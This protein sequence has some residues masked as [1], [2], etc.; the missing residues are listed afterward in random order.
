MPRHR[1]SEKLPN[2]LI[3]TIRSALG[4]E[5]PAH[6]RVHTVFGG[7]L[8]GKRLGISRPAM[9]GGKTAPAGAPLD[10][11][12]TLKDGIITRAEFVRGEPSIPVHIAHFDAG[13]GMRFSTVLDCF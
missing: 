2:R 11:Y 3:D 1:S 4:E 5:S 13:T 6:G 10:V 8:T 9:P 12:Y 7:G